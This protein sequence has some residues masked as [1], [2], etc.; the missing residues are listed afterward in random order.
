M[1]KL[2]SLWILVFCLFFSCVGSTRE[3]PVQ[4]AD[5]YTPRLEKILTTNIIPF[6]LHRCLDG[7]NGGY[8]INFDKN[9][10]KKSGTKMIVTQARMLWLFSR[11]A[12]KGYRPE[13]CLAAAQH[14]YRFLT[15]K[16]WDDKNGGFY[17]ETDSIGNVLKPKKH[18]YGQSFALYALSEYYMACGNSGVLDFAEDFFQLLEDKAYDKEFGGYREY[19]NTDWSLPPAVEISDMG[20]TRDV[21]LMNTHLHLMEAFTNY[22]RAFPSPLV[23][24]RLLELVII[25][26]TTVVRKDIGACTDKY[27]RDWTPD[28]E[29][30][31]GRV[32]YGHDLENIWLI[33]DACR[34]VG[35]Q[36]YP[37]HDTFRALF[38]NAVTFGYDEK[39]GGFYYNGPPASPADNRNKSWWVQAEAIVS[40]LY[41][42][43]LTGEKD[44]LPVFKTTMAMIENKLVDWQTGEWHSTV[45]QEGEA[46]GDKANAWKAGYHNGRAMLE[47]IDL[48]RDFSQGEK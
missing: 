16:M 12:R 40:A 18:L 28:L 36:T 7:K 2:V 14:G 13:E 3:E 39:N 32:S 6:W 42:Y 9:G 24:E 11:L 1:V 30:A 35:M 33:T 15:G 17:W 41:M 27:S 37:F 46:R 19:F 48:L 25:Q 31:S 44:Y 47:C 21:K 10:N 45:T 43:Q 38:D 4:L 26:S 8:I 23:R 22:Y 5:V 34:A 20:V 29:G